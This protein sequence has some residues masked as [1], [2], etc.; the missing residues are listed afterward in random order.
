MVT[1]FFF[2]SIYNL[3]KVV[4]FT[5]VKLEAETPIELEL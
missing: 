4:T 5:L 1:P 3:I 2:K